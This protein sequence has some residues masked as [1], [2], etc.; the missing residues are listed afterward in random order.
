VAQGLSEMS[1]RTLTCENDVRIS[2]FEPH[3]QHDAQS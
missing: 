3:L 2:G 1:F